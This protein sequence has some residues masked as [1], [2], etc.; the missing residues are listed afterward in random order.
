MRQNRYC[1]S[2]T[3]IS[4]IGN[5]NWKTS[6][7]AQKKLVSR[8]PHI[9]PNFA[10]IMVY[11]ILQMAWA[12]AGVK[13]GISPP[14]NWDSEPNI[15]SKSQV[16]SLIPINWLHFCNNSYF[17]VW[18]SHCPRTRFTVLMS[19]RLQ[20]THVRSFACKERLR[21]LRADCSTV[22]LCCVTITWPQR[23]A[24]NYDSRRF[25]A[26][27]CWTQKSWQVG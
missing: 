27:D 4:D 21:N 15:F 25:A 16:S 23:F 3:K 5:E 26:C 18:H 14:G 7:S 11:C 9:K 13:T 6:V 10:Q 22:I 2:N 20:F 19:C 12:S 24:S 1:L 8:A 17:P